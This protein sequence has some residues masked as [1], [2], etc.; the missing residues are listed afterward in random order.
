MRLRGIH[1]YFLLHGLNQ[2]SCVGW[3][4]WL[5]SNTTVHDMLQVFEHED[6]WHA[7][8]V[9]LGHVWRARTPRQ[10]VDVVGFKDVLYDSSCKRSGVVILTN[11][12]TW[13]LLE[14]W[15]DSATQ[16]VIDVTLD[17][18]THRFLPAH[19]T[20]SSKWHHLL[21]QTRH[22]SFTCSVVNTLSSI[23]CKQGV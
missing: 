22:R 12:T 23:N 1:S 9:L 5:L 8:G 7:T 16:N 20:P 18:P 17:S 13:L 4:V 10:H 14:T 11:D 21:N 15:H 2:F 3:R 19:D 6:P